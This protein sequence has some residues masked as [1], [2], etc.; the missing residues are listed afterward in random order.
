[1][2][3]H[4]S[5]SDI[6]GAKKP[7]LKKRWIITVVAGVV[8]IALAGT[9]A[10]VISLQT[11]AIDNLS[12]RLNQLEQQDS[13]ATMTEA[14]STLESSLKTVRSQTNESIVTLK[15][16]LTEQT[17][18]AEAT[19]AVLQQS[20]VALQKSQLQQDSRLEMIENQIDFLKEK[21]ISQS[22]STQKQ[23]SSKRAVPPVTSKPAKKPSP[24][25]TRVQKNKPSATVTRGAPF[26][27]TG[28]EKRG[29]E[30][31]AAIAPRGYS[32]LS[33][34]MLI[35][36]G[37]SVSGWTLV[38]AGYNQATFQVKGRLMIVNAE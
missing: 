8:V 19:T 36:E 11:Q 21:V 25:R 12:N 38:R 29:T 20:I 7:W 28:V 33:Q 31:W 18:N 23:T 14:L 30:S 4:F 13:T 17:D 2:S 15:K 24:A 9:A 10:T 22:S 1:M 6:Q 32:S 37:D 5:E 16:Q 27:L 3:E 34:I 26:V 35:S